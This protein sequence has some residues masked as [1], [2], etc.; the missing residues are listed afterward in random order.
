MR[1]ALDTFFT[2]LMLSLTAL[3]GVTAQGQTS[4]ETLTYTYGGQPLPIFRD[5]ANI[6]TF[7]Y[8]SVPRSIKIQDV[9]LTV[10]I[11]YPNPDD[12][13]VFLYS[14][15]GTRTKIVERNC[16]SSATLRNTIFDDSAPNRYSDFCP[17]EPGRVLRPNEPLHNSRGENAAGLWVLAVENNGSNDRIGWVLSYSLSITGEIY[18]TPATAPELIVNAASLAGGGVAPGELISIYGANIGPDEPVTA[19]PGNLPT[20]LGGTDVDFNEQKGYILYASKYRVDVQA[21]YAL[22]IPGDV[23]LTL[24]RNGQSTE[25]ANLAVVTSK[26]GLFSVNP[27]GRGQLEAI[28]A[29]GTLN[30]DETAARGSEITIFASGLGWTRPPIPAG[31]APAVKPTPVPWYPVTASIA[32]VVAEVREVS[33]TLNRPGVYEVRILIPDF[34]P[35]GPAA[36]RISSASASSQDGVFIRVR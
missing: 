16:S 7:V 8:I 27:S 12:L 9:K 24:N 4:V 25:P 13:N 14:A 20:S 17:A 5:D 21:P 6:I 3:L 10:D 1:K 23:W 2:L 36:V 11:D 15:A 28:N 29:D 18:V 19:E 30:K 33:L 35:P 34:V 31:Q 32:G 22:G 26:P